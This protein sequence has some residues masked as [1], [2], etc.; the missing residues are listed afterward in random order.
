MLCPSVKP[1]CIEVTVLIMSMYLELTKSPADCS[2]IVSI[3]GEE[4]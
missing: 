1:I 3:S 4:T 2:R